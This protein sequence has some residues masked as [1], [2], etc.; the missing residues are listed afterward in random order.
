MLPLSE[1]GHSSASSEFIPL[2]YEGKALPASQTNTLLLTHT[3]ISHPLR[4]SPSHLSFYQ[5]ASSHTL[6]TFL[7]HF[8][9]TGTG[10]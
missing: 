8:I 7:F 9:A 4:S 2:V 10:F 6:S 5:R 1:E 3:S